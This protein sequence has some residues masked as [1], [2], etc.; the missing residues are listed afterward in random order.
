MGWIF[1]HSILI[2]SL[3][4][5]T[6]LASYS[7]AADSEDF[8]GIGLSYF[9]QSSVDK[10]DSEFVHYLMP[11]DDVQSF[12]TSVLE[13][14]PLPEL[15]K[16][17]PEEEKP[18][19]P[20]PEEVEK[21]KDAKKD[22]KPKEEEEDTYGYFDY[23]PYGQYYHVDYWFGKAKWKN[24]AELGLNGQTGNTESNSLRVGAK[25]KREGDATVFSADIRHLRTSDK[26]GLTQNNA[27]V[28][29]KLEWP[30]KIHEKWSLFEKT[31]VEYDEFKAFDM[32]LVFN[33]GV[34]YKP[35]K[36]DATDWT[37]SIGSGF[38]QEYGS[39]QKGIIPEATLGSEL[40]H[41]ITE[42][43]SFQIKF[44]FFPAFEA[45]QGYRSVTD[46]SYT[47]ALDHGL[48]LKLSA[49]DRYDS[50]PNNR[51]RND[52]DYACLLIWQF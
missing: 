27:Y 36:T 8:D 22:E 15:P 26:D 43:Q 31:D 46:A 14:P 7:H 18:V 19:E 16:P 29:H 2:V 28:K 10:S 1:P 44:E 38:S 52:L 42:K 37:L 9:E 23:V 24:S 33:G 51:K 13:L 12:L 4:S 49:E 25:I 50:T 35:Y 47:I 39:P 45:N 6:T 20:T 17:K 48:S 3:I 40:T 30:L 21:P 41:Q 11:E 5:L 32:R 34:S